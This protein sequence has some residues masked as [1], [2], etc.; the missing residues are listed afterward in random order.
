MKRLTD[1]QSY[2]GVLPY[3]SE[4]FGV[5]QPLIGWTS[6]RQKERVERGFANDL[7]KARRGLLAKF[8]PDFDIKVSE[9][10]QRAEIAGLRVG[11]L[12]PTQPRSTGTFPVSYTHLTLPTKRIV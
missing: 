10:A 5:Y 1:L 4:L 12:E 8:R 3:S 11:T 2:K 9:R 7:E 6:K